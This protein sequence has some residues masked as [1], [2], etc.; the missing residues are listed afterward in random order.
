MSSTQRKT[1][2]WL[3]Y[4]SEINVKK[5]S[6]TFVYKGGIYES[7]WKRIHSIMLY[8]A[9][10]PLSEEFIDM[11]RRFKIPVCVH[12][13]NIAQ[14]T[15]ILPS[16]GFSREDILKKQ[17]LLEKIKRKD[18]TSHELYYSQNLSQCLI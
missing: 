16:V 3:P 8:G 5:S 11:C 2:L 14:A 12:R 17:I 6:V 1:P 15:W 4:V 18:F 10:C 7:Q 9:V 13:R